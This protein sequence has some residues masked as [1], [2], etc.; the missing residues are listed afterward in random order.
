MEKLLEVINRLSALLEQYDAIDNALAQMEMQKEVAYRTSDKELDS[1]R[2][3]LGQGIRVYL[4]Q[5]E[6][7]ER[8]IH[9]VSGMDVG[10]LRSRLADIKITL[11][12]FS[13]ID[14]EFRKLQKAFEI[15][16]EANAF[17]DEEGEGGSR[18][19]F[20]EQLG[21]LRQQ[22]EL[23]LQSLVKLLNNSINKSPIV[24]ATDSVISKLHNS[25]LTI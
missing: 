16:V 7:A 6:A 3:Q 21:R 10:E 9:Q 5:K 17:D 24:G 8:A 22:K 25:V 12:R 2:A 15:I 4:S 20:E 11:S 23:T 13:D 18:K 14:I 1:A 19:E